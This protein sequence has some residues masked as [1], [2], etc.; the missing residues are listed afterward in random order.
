[1]T[2]A[3]I[4]KAL[5]CCSKDRPL[6]KKECMHECPYFNVLDCKKHCMRNVVDLINRLKAD[7]DRLIGDCT[8]YKV[9][10]TKAV[11]S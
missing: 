8:T 3:E 10:W 11:S 6:T 4:I 9:R 1:M 7:N 2:D 5:E